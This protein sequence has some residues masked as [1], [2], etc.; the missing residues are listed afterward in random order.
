MA[1]VT[2]EDC[3]D[4]VRNRFELVMLSARRARQLSGG[5]PLT[6]DRDN[7]KNGVVALRE[8]AGETVAVEDLR[9][10]LVRNYQTVAENDFREEDEEAFTLSDEEADSLLSGGAPEATDAG[11]DEALSAGLETDEDSTS[12]DDM[13]A[14]ADEGDALG[15]VEMQYQDEVVEETP[16]ADQVAS[17]QPDTE[18]D[19]DTDEKPA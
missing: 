14:V 17:S 3:I 8:I 11:T 16:A 15:S 9:E 7:D 13:S 10:A 6:V 1:R 19:P 5:A 12:G 4:K 18:L 2:V